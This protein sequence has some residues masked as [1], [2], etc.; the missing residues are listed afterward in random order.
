MSFSITWHTLSVRPS[1]VCKLLKFQ[2]LPLKLLCQLEP[3]FTGI[4]F[5]RLCGKDV[6]E[7]VFV[8]YDRFL[9]HAECQNLFDHVINQT[10]L[11]VFQKNINKKRIGNALPL[12]VDLTKLVLSIGIG[13]DKRPIKIYIRVQSKRVRVIKAID[14]SL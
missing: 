5:R 6:P 1:V 8:M 12:T 10:R 11:V 7:Y 9:R 14:I 3:N 2:S 13:K 4:I